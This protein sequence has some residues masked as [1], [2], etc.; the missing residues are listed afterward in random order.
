MI[1]K[2]EH[3]GVKVKDMDVSIDFYTKVL[4]MKLVGRKR[5]NPDRELG[6][7]SLPGDEH[8][9]RLGG[10]DHRHETSDSY[11]SCGPQSTARNTNRQLLPVV[12]LNRI[13]GRQLP[14]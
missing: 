13:H 11:G 6:F 4:G 7:L 12:V 9:Q 1:H 5:L 3:I 8:I 2:L 14:D 10:A